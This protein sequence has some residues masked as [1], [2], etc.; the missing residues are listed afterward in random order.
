MQIIPAIN[1]PDLET[2]ILQ[3]D[4]ISRFLPDGGWVHIDIVDGMFSKNITWND[5]SELSSLKPSY[6]GLNFEIHLMVEDP[7][8]FVEVWFMNG[9]SR[10][11][12]HLEAVNN[13]DYILDIA[14]RYDGE[15][16]LSIVPSTPADLLMPQVGSFSSFQ[17]LAVD[18][19]FTGQEFSME[20]LEKIKFLRNVSPSA[21][22]EVD[23]GINP[24]TARLAKI[25]GA[26]CAVS[27]SYIFNNNISPEEAYE[28]LNGAVA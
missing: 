9:A 3:L 20:S 10:V 16:T 22:I 11:I 13:P 23:G 17:I 8:E 19:G 6:P 5:P 14:S 27:A 28:E 25:A 1:C 24:E 26:D 2:L 21:K 15:A 7:D 18:P 4:E 12:V